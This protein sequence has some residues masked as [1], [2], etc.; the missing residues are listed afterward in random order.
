MEEK[1][2]ALLIKKPEKGLE[3]LI[4]QYAG[5]VY[6]IVH[7]QLNPVC[8]RED[9]EECVS[10][11][12]FEVYEK[13]NSIDLSRGT[14]KAFLAVI[15]QRR[16]IDLYRKK[17]SSLGKTVPLQE[18]EAGSGGVK[19]NPGADELAEEYE[20]KELL[21]SSIKALGEP[22]S[23]I[24]IRRYY[25]GQK[26]R[27]IAA[28]LGLKENTVDKKISRGL[29]KLRGVFKGESGWQQRRDI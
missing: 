26:T 21:I 9:I 12:F 10:S 25:F 5:L 13:R 11:V 22:D 3:R 8:P 18:Y 1:L 16:A 7:R 6:A 29:E 19:M 27:M 28:A 14:L 4:N 23:E 20:F 24:F 15:A 2:L 17:G